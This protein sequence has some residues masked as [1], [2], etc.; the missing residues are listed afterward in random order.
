MDDKRVEVRIDKWLWAVRLFKTRVKAQLA[1]KNGKISIG[2]KICKPSKIVKV[3]DVI[4]IRS[5]SLLKEVRIKEIISKRV[6]AKI[7]AELYEENK[8]ILNK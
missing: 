7:A 3:D 4:A 2:E 1:C 8:H 6:S 5:G